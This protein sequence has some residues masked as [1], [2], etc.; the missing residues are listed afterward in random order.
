LHLGVG[1]MVFVQ[2]KE[3]KVFETEGDYVI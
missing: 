2:P 3:I 1:E